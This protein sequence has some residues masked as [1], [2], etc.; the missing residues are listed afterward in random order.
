MT[1]TPDRLIGKTFG[2]LKVIA[3]N[4]TRKKNNYWDCV[5]SCGNART[6]QEAH[7]I[8]GQTKSCGCLRSERDQNIHF[9]IP[10]QDLIIVFYRNM[11]AYFLIGTDDIDML[12]YTWTGDEHGYHI[13][14][15]SV[16]NGKKVIYGRLKLGILGESKYQCDHINHVTYDFRSCNIRKATALQNKCNTERGIGSVKCRD[17]V[18]Y[19]EI[20]IEN[21]EKVTLEPFASDDEARAALKAWL[22]N[23][24]HFREFTY[25][26]S[27]EI[28]KANWSHILDDN[29]GIRH[30]INDEVDLVDEIKQLPVRNLYRLLLMRWC[31]LLKDVLEGKNTDYTEEDVQHLIIKTLGDYKKSKRI[32]S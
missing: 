13:D 17:G 30:F 11:N 6:V 20:P 32:A 9:I 7:L 5:C 23:S 28:S 18:W 3:F 27:Q 29:W 2:R 15:I 24:D 26:R 1:K 22:K 12:E 31:A 14:P 16:I 19:A 8:S 4:S 21:G 25:E 10:E